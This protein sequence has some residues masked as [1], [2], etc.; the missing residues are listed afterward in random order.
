MPRLLLSRL[1]DRCV[2]IAAFA[3]AAPVSAAP[4]RKII[5]DQ[6]AFGPGGSNMQALLLALQAPDVEVLGI[7]VTSGDGWRDENV[8]HTLRLL[9]LVGRTEIPVVPGAVFPLINSKDA[10]LRWEK[11]HGALFYKGAWMDTYPE[12]P[13]VERAPGHGP[14]EIPPLREGSPSIKALA[15]SAAAFM[16]RKVREFPGEVTIIQLGPATNAALAARLDPGF[17]SLTKEFVIMGGSFNP[18]PADNSFALEYLYTPRLEFNFR[19]DPEAMS[20]VLR[21]PWPK[22]TLLPVDPTTKTLF[23]PA[24]I[25][26]CTTNPTPVTRYI[27]KYAQGFPLWDE[28]AVAIWL[29]PEIVTVRQPVAVAVDVDQGAGYGNTLSWPAGHGPGLGEQTADVIFNIDLVRFENLCAELFN[30]VLPPVTSQI[31]PEHTPGLVP[32]T[33]AGRDS[34]APAARLASLTSMHASQI[35]AHL[36]MEKIPAEGAWFA[37]TYTSDDH[38]AAASLPSRYGSSRLAGTAIYALV[39]HEDFSALHRLKTDEIWH[40]YAGDPIELLLLRPDGRDERVII[41]PDLLSGQKPQ[42]TVPAGVWMGARPLSGSPEAYT[43]FGCTLAPGFDYADFEPG[44]RDELQK[45][46]PARSSLIAELTRADFV[47]RPATVAGLSPETTPHDDATGIV[48]APETVA[49]ITAAPGVVLRELIGRVGHARS[50]A[51]SVARFAL[52]PGTG[53]GTSYNKT[54]E[55]VFLIISGHGRVKLAGE[56]K[57]VTAGDVVVMKPGLRHSLTAAPDEGLEFYAI[58]YPAFSPDDYVRVD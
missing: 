30:R 38:L 51:C 27:K 45:S 37:L 39:T 48:F 36:H 15:E 11:I 13:N 6:D 19:W 40:Y 2:L 20:I 28:L 42:F 49:A 26:R 16:I 35:I 43:L 33:V 17:V 22:L 1:L 56:E 4:A 57:P 54:G 29:R 58:T 12:T 7:T 21:S 14:Y 18:K 5:L 55:E 44:Y 32:T 31:L 25:A 9:E 10:T 47:H 23:S 24:L 8:A 52:A 3:L 46:H 41:G 50:N 34:L 53:T